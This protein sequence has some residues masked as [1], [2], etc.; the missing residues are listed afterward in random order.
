MD[1][2][3]SDPRVLVIGSGG[4]EILMA[5]RISQSPLVE[6]VY[7]YP[8]NASA[9]TTAKISH[10]TTLD[11]QPEDGPEGSDQATYTAL[12]RTAREELGIGLVVVGPGEAAVDGAEEY[13]AAAAAAVARATCTRRARCSSS[14]SSYTILTRLPWICRLLR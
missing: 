11:I 4:R 8:G 6:H 12:A 1:I 9:G 2:K 10:I 14:P 3:T 13:F 5:W 7:L